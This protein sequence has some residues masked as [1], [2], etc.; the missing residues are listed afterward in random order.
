[1]SSLAQ[2]AANQ[3]NAQLSSGPRTNDGKAAS[4]Q[5]AATHALTGNFRVLP[6]EEQP[7]FD[8]L[9]SS[10]KN[11]WKPRSQDETFLVEQMVQSRWK[12]ARIN[13]LEV[14]VVS[15]MCAE[16]NEPKSLDGVIVSAMLAKTA[17]AWTTLQRYAA[18]AE[19]TY[20]RC[21]RELMR[22]REAEAKIAAVQSS[23]LLNA[24]M[25]PNAAVL[26]NEPKSASPTPASR[27]PTPGVAFTDEDP[28]SWRL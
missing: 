21:R 24:P 22:N 20:H 2:I 11:E 15:R 7:A 16:Q 8:A 13:R 9:L 28:L 5:N 12:L 27:R 10:Y 23:A 4:S 6:H 25:R 1:M 19:R 18:A 3:K 26:P 17:D 14:E